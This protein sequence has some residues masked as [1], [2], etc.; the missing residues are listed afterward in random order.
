MTLSQAPTT[1]EYVGST[2]QG[3]G[4]PHL[5]ESQPLPQTL[6]AGEYLVKIGLSTICGSDLHTYVGRRS[7]PT[8]CILGHEAMGTVVAV[9]PGSPESYLQKRV[10]WTLSASCGQCPPCQD[11]GLPQKCEKLVKYGHAPLTTDAMMNG[12]FASHLRLLKGTSVVTLPDN[13]SDALAAPANCALATMMSVVEALPKGTTSVLIQGAGLLGLYGILLLQD[14]GCPTITIVDLDPERLALAKTFG[15][16]HTYL[17][18]QLP[19]KGD[20]DAAVEVA[21]IASIVPEGLQRLRVGGTYILAGLVHPQSKLDLTGQQIIQKSITL[22]GIHNYAPRHLEKAID[23]L[24][25]FEAKPLLENLVSPPYPLE[26]I[27][28]AFDLA[29]SK[30]WL[31]VS[32]RSIS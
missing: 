26:G 29:Q 12:C 19:P 13:V 2:F 1:E 17:P 30:R 16:T 27:D 28:E 23:F 25:R 5:V 7:A 31:R 11:W 3:P 20:Y 21:G 32:L 24:H 4:R 10:T 15:A 8:P 6:E 18:D 14:L 22:K 9:G